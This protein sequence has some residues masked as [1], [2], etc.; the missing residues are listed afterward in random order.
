MFLLFVL[1]YINSRPAIYRENIP[2]N[3]TLR[4]FDV[5][6]NKLDSSY[7]NLNQ[8]IKYNDIDFI[9]L[10]P[11]FKSKIKQ[12]YSSNK[13]DLTSQQVCG[14]Y[15]D[16][17]DNLYESN[18]KIVDKYT[19]NKILL[20]ENKNEIINNL[21]AK[22][23]QNLENIFPSKNFR[24]L[25]VK[26]YKDAIYVKIS[27]FDSVNVDKDAEIFTNILKK[28]KK[29]SK[30][31]VDLRDNES[32]NL[33]YALNVVIKPLLKSSINVDFKVANK[34]HPII[35]KKL[36]AKN[37]ITFKTTNYSSNLKIKDNSKDIKYITTFNLKVNASNTN[38]RDVYILQNKNTKNS[39]DFVCQIANR[40]RFA[41]TVGETTSGNGLNIV[42]T[43]I[44]LPNTGF[45]VQLPLGQGINEDG[46]TNEEEGTNP[47]IKLDDSDEI[48]KH[49][50]SQIN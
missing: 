27:D 47:V 44:S 38:E 28:Y 26:E 5:L 18:V 46:S 39:A 41:S 20:Q 34:T 14:L 11:N 8:T 19:F 4:D 35:S 22:R 40:T 49:L 42:H 31:I 10:K 15:N 2:Q 13:K 32:E 48:V 3:Y 30:I 23:Y 17:L 21:S 16:I 29:K 43:Y 45:L 24:A 1:K 33:D 7:M 36:L 37:N 25:D 12:A 9:S 6:C 50:L